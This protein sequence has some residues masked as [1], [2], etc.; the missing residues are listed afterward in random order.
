MSQEDVVWKR[1]WIGWLGINI[2]T[3]I[4]HGDI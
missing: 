1:I 2:D 3:D 4:Q